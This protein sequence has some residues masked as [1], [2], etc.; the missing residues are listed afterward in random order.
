MATRLGYLRKDFIFPRST[1]VVT[2]WYS[3]YSVIHTAS[4]G[5][6]HQTEV[7]DYM[8]SKK[9]VELLTYLKD[10]L[11]MSSSANMTVYVL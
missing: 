8:H 1:N 9:L 3:Q 6:V 5:I 2:S 11:F 7:N 4:Q 10:L